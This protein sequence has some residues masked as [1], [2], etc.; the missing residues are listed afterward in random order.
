M[1]RVK[2]CIAFVMIVE[3]RI[4]SYSFFLSGNRAF[5]GTFSITLGSLY[6]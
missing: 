3:H 5:N 2:T 4:L 1:S 6:S